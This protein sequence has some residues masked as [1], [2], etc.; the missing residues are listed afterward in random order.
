MPL[1]SD[2]TRFEAKGA[3]TSSCRECSGYVPPEGSRRISFTPPG[4]SLDINI[5][6]IWTSVNNINPGIRYDFRSS[7]AG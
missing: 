7:L 5:L 3:S 6:F 4:G 2:A 1:R